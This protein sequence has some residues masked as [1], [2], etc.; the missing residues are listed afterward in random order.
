MCCAHGIWCISQGSP[1]EPIGSICIYY[2][3]LARVIMETEKSQD[4]QWT[5]W[6]PGEP[7]CTSSPKAG[8][9]QTLEEPM[10]QF[11]S[12]GRKR[13]VFLLNNQAGEVPFYLREGQPFCSIQ[14]F[15]ITEGNLLYSV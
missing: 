11:E 8:R 13:S 6:R 10:F 9:L 14:A 12:E 15:S 4:L 2:K 7:M 1:E 5:S 3:E